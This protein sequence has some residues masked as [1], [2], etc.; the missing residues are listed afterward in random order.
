M[1]GKLNV[2]PMMNALYTLIHRL[3]DVYINYHIIN[4][5]LLSSD[6]V[7][8]MVETK[9]IKESITEPDDEHPFQSANDAESGASTA[10][11]FTCPAT[12]PARDPTGT[13]TGTVSASRSARARATTASAPITETT[14]RQKELSL[15]VGAGGD[16]NGAIFHG[17]GHGRDWFDAGL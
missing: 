15:G 8:T 2:S 7:S 9:D 14:I 17:G 11:Q 4:M 5:E 12:D 16:V 1:G 10:R 6:S 13:A 3:R